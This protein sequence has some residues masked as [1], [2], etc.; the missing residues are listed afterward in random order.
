MFDPD[1]GCRRYKHAWSTVV[2]ALSADWIPDGREPQFE[3]K[4]CSGSRLGD[5]IMRQ[6]DQLTRPKVVLL[7]AGGNDADFYPMADSCL[8]RSDYWTDY[9]DPYDKDDPKDPKGRCRIEIGLVRERV[10][11]N[12]IKDKMVDTINR[13]RAHKAVTGNDA[14]LFVLGYPHMFGEAEFCNTVSFSVQYRFFGRT[15]VVLEMRREFN[16]LVC[17][18]HTIVNSL[19]TALYCRLIT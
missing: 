4:A 3:F 18:F 14:S 15:N 9:G 17:K 10:Q 12:T 8:F 13:W 16:D 5:D 19:T 7:E 6:M 11:G 1:T 2:N